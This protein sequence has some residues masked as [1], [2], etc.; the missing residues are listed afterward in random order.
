[1]TGLSLYF[2]GSCTS[3]VVLTRSIW[4]GFGL[5]TCESYS[6]INSVDIKMGFGNPERYTN[7]IYTNKSK[8][9][10]QKP[11][12]N[13]CEIKNFCKEIQNKFKDKRQN[14]REIQ[15]NHPDNH[16]MMMIALYTDDDDDLVVQKRR[17][18]SWWRWSHHTQGVPKVYSRKF[19]C[20]HDDDRIVH[21]WWWSRCTQMMMIVMMKMI[22]S[23]TESEYCYH[24]V[25]VVHG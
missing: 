2:F 22:A 24:D 1:M 25:R 13:R 7:K 6:W 19:P 4:F 20:Y 16:N 17:W 10:T 5:N 8:K 12:R 14:H 15:K 18:L 3:S 11:K 9:I 21:G 23:Y